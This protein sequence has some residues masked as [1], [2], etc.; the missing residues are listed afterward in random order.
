[1]ELRGIA[2]MFIAVV[3]CAWLLGLGPHINAFFAWLLQFHDIARYPAWNVV[4]DAG[5]KLGF[6][7]AVVAL[8][9]GR[10]KT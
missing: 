8:I 2:W 7:L 4:L 5:V 9:L 6:I 3:I 10:K 1:M